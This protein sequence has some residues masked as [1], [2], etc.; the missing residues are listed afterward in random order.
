VNTS[1]NRPFS[2]IRAAV[3]GA[4]LLTLAGTAHGALL[5]LDPGFPDLKAESLNIQYDGT[6]SLLIGYSGATQD[7]T[8][9]PS[10][11]AA[12]TTVSVNYFLMSLTVNPNASSSGSVLNGTGSLAVRNGG[13]SGTVILL[14]DVFRFGYSFTDDPTGQASFAS[15]FFD[16]EFS[17]T[18]ASL[19]FQI[20]SNGIFKGG[21]DDIT[22][23]DLDLNGIGWAGTAFQGTSGV[24]T[25]DITGPNVPLPPTALLLLPGLA[26]GAWV[27]RRRSAA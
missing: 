26:A 4:A 2:G 13:A 12:S 7:W 24:G 11:G 15:A 10:P 22:P 19:D 23:S 27:R 25:A 21:F 17:I 14:G 6:T 1:S 18:D 8:Y 5:G 16:A 9:I 20:G 3:L